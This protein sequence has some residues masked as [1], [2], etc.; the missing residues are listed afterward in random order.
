ML[1]IA[2]SSTLGGIKSGTDITVNASGDVSV[3]DD[4]HNHIVSNIDGLQTILD[5]KIDENTAITGA[6][7]AK[8]NL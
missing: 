4:S 6:T 8:N 7:K 1:P 2:T 5:G 3:N